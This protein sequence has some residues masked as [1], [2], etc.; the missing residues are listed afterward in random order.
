MP[1]VD[2]IALLR[3]YVD[4]GSESAFAAIVQ[5]RVNLVYS[6]RTFNL[7]SAMVDASLPQVRVMPTKFPGQRGSLW[8]NNAATKWAG[9]NMPVSV[10][11]WVAYQ[12]PPARVVFAGP[13]P[14]GRYDFI[15]SLPQDSY[16]AL[17]RELKDRSGVVGRPETRDVNALVL[18]VKT[19]DATG[20]KP[21]IVGSQRDTNETGEYVCD[22][23]ALSNDNPPFQGL[24]RFLEDRFNMPVVDETGLTNHY[25]I[26]LKWK[27]LGSRDRGNQSLKQALLDQL[28]LELV[29]AKESIE[30]LVVENA[31]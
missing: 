22:D 6:W 30:M 13:E 8:E 29:P 14:R 3:E 28:G 12:W 26:D 20:L 24:Q 21:P 27:E 25:S 2:D 11:M 15:T 17:Q 16:G 23:R 5:R 7:D 1:D 4:A 19:P 18:K 31:K 9:L 10:M